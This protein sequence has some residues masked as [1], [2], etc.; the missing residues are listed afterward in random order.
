M[1]NTVA[2]EEGISTVEQ[3]R[4]RLQRRAGSLEPHRSEPDQRGARRRRHLFVDRRSGEMGRRALRR[5]VA[6]PESLQAAFTP[7]TPHRRSRGAIWLRL[8]HHRRDAVALRR[9]DRFRNVIVRYPQRTPDGGR[10]HQPQRARAVSHCA[11][12]RR[13]VRSSSRAQRTDMSSALRPSGGT[14]AT[15]SCRNSS[16]HDTAKFLPPG[17]ATNSLRGARSDGREFLRVTRRRREVL[18]ALDNE[19][20]NREL[21]AERLRVQLHVC[22]ISC[23]RS[24]PGR[25]SRTRCRR[26]CSRARSLAAPNMPR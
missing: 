10:A 7:A 11:R 21:P 6:A 19:D 14:G 23:S 16:D 3:P 25:R 5:A 20:G 26:T 2:Y 9:D 18:G 12:D 8:A 13:T 24:A 17:I 15:S 4:V 1:N 22:G